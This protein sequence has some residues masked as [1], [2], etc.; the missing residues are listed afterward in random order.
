MVREEK[1]KRE[2]IFSFFVNRKGIIRYEMSVLWGDGVKGGR[3]AIGRR[4]QQHKAQA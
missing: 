4:G 1:I 2:F 3:L